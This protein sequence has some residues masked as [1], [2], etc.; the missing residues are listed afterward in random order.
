MRDVSSLP[1]LEQ[2]LVRLTE[3][4][5]FL[6]TS[7]NDNNKYRLQYL[8]ELLTGLGS[9]L[10]LEDLQNNRSARRELCSITK[11]R[12]E[13]AIRFAG[14]DY[15][16]FEQKGCF[17][18]LRTKINDYIAKNSTDINFEM[19]SQDVDMSGK[20]LYLSLEKK[21]TKDNYELARKNGM[22]SGNFIVFISSFDK[23]AKDCPIESGNEWECYKKMLSQVVNMH[24]GMFKLGN[25]Q[26]FQC[27]EAIFQYLTGKGYDSRTAASLVA[28]LIFDT[29][30]KYNPYVD[31]RQVSID[32]NITVIFSRRSRFPDNY[33]NS[34][35]SYYQQALNH[36]PIE[37][38]SLA[39]RINIEDE[40]NPYDLY[41][42]SVYKDNHDSGA[43]CDYIN[44]I[45]S[46]YNY[47]NDINNFY[48]QILHPNYIYTVLYHE[49]GHAYDY[50]Y[51]KEW[52]VET[53]LISSSE[54]WI[55]AMKEDRELGSNPS[56]SPYGENSNKEDFAD[57][58]YLYFLNPSELDKFPNRKRLLDEKFKSKKYH[59]ELNSSG[60]TLD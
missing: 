35:I 38:K 6:S 42:R 32:N 25:D 15:S 11:E 24:N 2:W 46:I 50:H 12:I 22:A 58:I 45:I 17:T 43:T 37:L 26:T 31:E 14:G 48:S 10:N 36:L 34:I 27:N 40:R 4:L 51:A 53:E 20:I 7:K 8:E 44:G 3:E 18:E 59:A 49:L 56:V 16:E 52:G 33:Y 47:E 29:Y 5:D 55:N 39:K 21:L 54:L 60:V 57:C 13:R 9:I 41:W 23:A 28:W 19:D 1:I 30:D